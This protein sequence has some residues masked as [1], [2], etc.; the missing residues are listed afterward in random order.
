MQR[1]E[2]HYERAEVIKKPELWNPGRRAR[3]N[4]T[5][6]ETRL[7]EIDRLKRDRLAVISAFTVRSDVKAFALFI[8]GHT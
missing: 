2:Q 7:R 1:F 8:F 3:L 6:S 4:Q 5:G